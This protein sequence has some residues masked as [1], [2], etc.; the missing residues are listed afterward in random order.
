M[1]SKLDSSPKKTKRFPAKK[2]VIGLIIATV[3]LLIGITAKARLNQ[4]TNVSSPQVNTQSVDEAPLA[5]TDLNAHYNFVATDASGNPADQVGFLITKA[6]KTKQVLIQGRP[7]NAKGDKAFL[8]LHIEIENASTNKL[9]LAPVNLLRLVDDQ[10]KKF[11][12]DI[13]SDTVEIQPISTK[14]TRVG[15]VVLAD[16]PH[17][18]IQVGELEGDKQDLEINF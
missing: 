7:A 2:I 15:F 11:A 13:H 14:I 1:I 10:G 6:E 3:L 4:V 12:P 16:Q 8:V 9:Y 17:F 18:L 5:T